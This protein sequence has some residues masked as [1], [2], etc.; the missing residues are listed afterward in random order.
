MLDSIPAA[1]I[2]GTALGFLSGLVFHWPI[3]LVYLCLRSSEIFTCIAGL[4]RLCG[5]RWIVD[6]TREKK[7]GP[8]DLAEERK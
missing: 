5:T 3:W 6:V 7:Q 4:V 2:V 1:L 8:S